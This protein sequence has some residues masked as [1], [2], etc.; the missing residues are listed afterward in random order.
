[1]IL[2]E[3]A[4]QRVRTG[5]SNIDIAT[6]TQKYKDYGIEKMII[7]YLYKIPLEDLKGL[8]K[9]N[10]YHDTPDY[11]P[12]KIS[13]GYY[14]KEQKGVAEINIYLYHA[15]A[16]MLVE[17][18]YTWLRNK[19]FLMSFGKLFIASTLF[20]EIGHHKYTD[21]FPKKYK[22]KEEYEK[23]AV[24]YANKLLWEVFP[25][26][27]RHYHFFNNIY[28]ILYKERIKKAEKIGMNEVNSKN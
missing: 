19:I 10:I 12:R 11:F 15:L 27:F 1:M 25:F 3:S 2:K 18:P 9:I 13:G 24:D 23:D 16:Y 5:A 22:D 14:S 6:Y 4:T 21:V 17:G 26:R 8:G 7:K 20:H 28:K